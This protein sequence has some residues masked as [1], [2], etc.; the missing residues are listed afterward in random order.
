MNSKLS[1]TS[2]SKI[3]DE[4]N[5]KMEEKWF[6]IKAVNKWKK[7][8][9]IDSIFDVIPVQNVGVMLD[10]YRSISMRKY[11]SKLSGEYITLN[12]MGVLDILLD[13]YKNIE[14]KYKLS[15]MSNKELHYYNK[16]KELRDII[17][18][19]QSDIEKKIIPLMGIYEIRDN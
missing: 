11:A 1:V 19:E 4:L 8:Y 18:L 15:R 6:D 10:F 17:H 5:I 3:V 13:I 12:V 2:I 7:N 16:M 9:Q 14:D